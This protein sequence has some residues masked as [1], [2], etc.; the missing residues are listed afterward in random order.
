MLLGRT[1]TSGLKKIPLYSSK[2]LT[3]SRQLCKLDEPFSRNSISKSSRSVACRRS[4]R[5]RIPKMI[6]ETL[7]TP[8]QS[9]RE[10]ASESSRDP[11]GSRR[12]GDSGSRKLCHFPRSTAGGAGAKRHS[13]IPPASRQRQS[14]AMRYRRSH[15]CFMGVV[16]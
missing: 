12:C 2:R 8:C 15:T 13:S 1:I 9:C 14:V 7:H 6:Q 11:N 4:R 5:L 10:R 16:V 3:C